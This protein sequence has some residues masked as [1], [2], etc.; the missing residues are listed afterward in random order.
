VDIHPGSITSFDDDE[1][2][3]IYMISSRKKR[4]RGRS[5]RVDT[6]RQDINAQAMDAKRTWRKV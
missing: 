1:Q 2:V 6:D 5:G 3:T 4:R